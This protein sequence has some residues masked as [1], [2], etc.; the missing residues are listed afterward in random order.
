MVT[1]HVVLGGQGK[2]SAETACM[3]HRAKSILKVASTCVILSTHVLSLNDQTD[4]AFFEL[5][6]FAFD[7]VM[8]PGGENL[9]LWGEG[10]A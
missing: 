10:R 7:L 3:W 6:V 1:K 4:F 5:P 2:N 9:V 8:K